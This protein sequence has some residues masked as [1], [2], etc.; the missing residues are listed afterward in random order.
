MIQ[1]ETWLNV[2]DNSGAKKVECIKVLGGTSRRYASIGDVIIV[3][4]K[5]ALPNGAVKKGTVAKAV[6]VR[7]TKEY[8][9]KDGTYI[10]FSDNAA[11][12]INDTGEPKGTRIFGPVAR[13]LREKQ[14]MKIVSLAPEVL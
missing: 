14:F 11:V 3:S 9:R 13:E 1:E 8:G 2:A 6:I 5:D 12:I 10:R 7:T 4:V